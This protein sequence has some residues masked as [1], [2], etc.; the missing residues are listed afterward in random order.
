MRVTKGTVANLGNEWPGFRM[1]FCI[2]PTK[3][4]LAD[5]TEITAIG[6]T[7]VW[8]MKRF[9]NVCTWS[10]PGLLNDASV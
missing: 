2:L 6:S 7:P 1:L 3:K 5:D 10:A 8:F 9:D 4:F